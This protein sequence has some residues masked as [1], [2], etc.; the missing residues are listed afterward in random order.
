MKRSILLNLLVLGLVVA[1]GG[2]GCKHKAKGLTPITGQKA[3]V[4]GPGAGPFVPAGGVGTGLD[5]TGVKPLDLA[6]GPEGTTALAGLEN[7]ENFDANRDVFK[8]YIVYFDF[9][10]STVREGE[11]SKVEA[12]AAYLKTAPADNALL[13]EGHC[14]ERGTEEYNRA[15]GERRALALR[16]YL[17]NLGVGPERI[18]TISYGK[19]KPLDMAHDESAWAKNRRGEFLLLTPKK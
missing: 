15:L 7:F 10:R 5:T 19:D 16:E 12:V 4:A 9:D 11:R 13:I 2:M 14:D 18:R 6:K 8:A 1:I 3:A 17:T